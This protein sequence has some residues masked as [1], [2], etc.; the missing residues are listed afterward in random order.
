MGRAIGAVLAGAVVWAVLWL[1]MNAVLPT[2]IPD[3]YVP[4]QRLES[5]PVL[6]FLIGYSV[7]LS[8]LA[9]YVTA[10]VRGPD[11]MPTVRVLAGL[12]LTFGVVAQAASWALLPVWYH[13]VFLALIVPATLYGGT[14]RAGSSTPN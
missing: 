8:I 6:L 7:V 9:G 3:L 10:A 2:V 1:G 4:G 11:P 14:L 13:L 5:P 12:Q